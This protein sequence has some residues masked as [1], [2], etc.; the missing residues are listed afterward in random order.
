VAES[1]AASRLIRDID[2]YP[3]MHWY[4]HGSGWWELSPR[5]RGYLGFTEKIKNLLSTS[6]FGLQ[7][8]L[9][10]QPYFRGVE[11]SASKP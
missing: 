1:D 7:V 10:V 2:S 4:I 6:D 5:L 8:G 3:G 11:P 9:V